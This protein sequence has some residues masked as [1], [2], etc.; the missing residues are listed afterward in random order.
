[1]VDI[2]GI[3]IGYHVSTFCGKKDAESMILNLSGKDYL[4]FL[5]EEPIFVF[6]LWL[7]EP[8]LF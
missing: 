6:V 1:M 3:N 4:T 8:I 5:F 2:V 7:Y